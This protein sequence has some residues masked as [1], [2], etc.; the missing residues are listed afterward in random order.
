MAKTSDHPPADPRLR[1]FRIGA[2]AVYLVVVGV[3]TVLVTTSVVRSVRAM[4][5]G[6]R[7]ASEVT[8][9]VR[10]CIQ[11]AEG[12]FQE[13]ERERDRLTQAFPARKLDEAWVQFRVGWLERFRDA[14][15]RCA[16]QSRGREPLRQVFQQLDQVMDLYTIAAVQY[17]G[18]M[19]GAVDGLRGSLDA[20]KKDPA[21][22]RLP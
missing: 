9:T 7:P 16:V 1:A 17:A 8:L 13:L 12:L 18:E 15:A 21:A 2:Y 4:T 19:G 20:A 6:R 22:G 10:E 11:R 3:M 14:E 5:P